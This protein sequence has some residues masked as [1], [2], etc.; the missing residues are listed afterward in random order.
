MTSAKDQQAHVVE[1]QR[2]CVVVVQVGNRN[3]R[4]LEGVQFGR[5]DVINKA[6]RC[7]DGIEEPA[8]QGGNIELLIGLGFQ[9][10]DFFDGWLT[11]LGRPGLS[12]GSNERHGRR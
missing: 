11:N 12:N 5:T 3:E 9:A 1:G 4:C 6:V 7:Q 8:L 10:I 2:T